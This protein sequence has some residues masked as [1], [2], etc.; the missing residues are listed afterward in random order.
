[1]AR[2]EADGVPVAPHA[3]VKVLVGKVLMPSQGVGIREG[4]VQLQGSLEQPDG[5]IVLL[6]QAETVAHDGPGPRAPP[7]QG[8]SFLGQ[9]PQ[10]HLPLHM[11][12]DCAVHLHA[13]PPPDHAAQARENAFTR[14]CP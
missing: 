2:V 3:L 12:Q 7:V 5:R 1:M 8:H 13:L 4:G 10:L 6:L 11:P 14:E 9:V